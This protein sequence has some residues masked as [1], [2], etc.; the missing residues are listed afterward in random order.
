MEEMFDIWERPEAQELYMIVGWRQWAD[1]GSISSEL[2]RYL[3]QQTKAKK[4]GEIHSDGFYL[5]QF[6]GTHDL[7]RPTVR[8]EEGRPLSLKTPKNELFYSGDDQRGVILLSGDEPHVDAER[9]VATLLNIAESLGVKRIV[10]LGGVYGELPYDKERFV[11]CIYS[12]PRMAEEVKA[13]A[14][15]L[16]DYQGGASIG[17]YVCHRAGE[18]DLE[19]VGFYAFVPTYDFSKV[20]Q[21]GN[22]IRIENDYMAWLGVMRRICYMLHLDLDLSELEAKSE[23]LIEVIDEKIN[24]LDRLVPQL[25][26]RDYMERLSEDFTEVVFE[27]LSEVWEEELRRL[28]GNDEA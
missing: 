20:T 8:F 7:L 6:P 2:P 4:I 26:V 16:S 12:L 15:D 1:A 22:A 11:S 5:F 9:Y 23:E 28:F 17:S 3:I 24:E 10:S 14:V 19:F 27:P 18:R 21:I 13:L 25:N